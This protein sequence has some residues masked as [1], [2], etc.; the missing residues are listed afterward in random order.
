[1]HAFI[2]DGL[3]KLILI[4]LYFQLV[5]RN[6]QKFLFNVSLKWRFPPLERHLLLWLHNRFRIFFF[7]VFVYGFNQILLKTFFRS[8]FWLVFRSLNDQFFSLMVL[9]NFS[10]N[11]NIKFFVG[12]VFVD[13]KIR[14]LKVFPY[15]TMIFK[16]FQKMEQFFNAKFIVTIND[17]ICVIFREIFVEK[18]WIILL[19]T[20]SEIIPFLFFLL[21]IHFYIGIILLFLFVSLF[22]NFVFKF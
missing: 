14:E 12:Y 4:F 13:V 22:N 9:V 8:C 7:K 6:P 2:F 3:I 1:M 17:Q 5:F 21:R 16:V 18:L 15:F 10:Q 19:L 11:K 20:L